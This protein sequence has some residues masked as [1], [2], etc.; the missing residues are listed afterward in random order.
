MPI[1]D[2]P[3]TPDAGNK[4]DTTSGDTAGSTP[5][6]GGS[7]SVRAPI[8]SAWAGQLSDHVVEGVAWLK[9][10]TTAPVLTVLKAIVYGLVVLCAVVS[11]LVFLT[12]GLVRLWDVYVPLSPLGRRVWLGYVLLGALLALA[13]VALLAR[14]RSAS[15]G[16]RR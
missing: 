3:L 14:K 12:I 8:G 13:G 6:G 5:A 9:A 4:H 7:S 1:G 15:G 11:A 16:D 2:D 10:R